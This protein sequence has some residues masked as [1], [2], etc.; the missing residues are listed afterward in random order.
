MSK[1]DIFGR[2]LSKKKRKIDKIGFDVDTSE[3]AIAYRRLMFR[4]AEEA[5]QRG[6]EKAYM[7]YMSKFAGK[8]LD[9][10]DDRQRVADEFEAFDDSIAQIISNRQSNESQR[11]PLFGRRKTTTVV[12]EV[13]HDVDTYYE[14]LSKEQK[15]SGRD[16]SNV[17]MS[18]TRI[19]P[20][21]YKPIP[22]GKL[23]IKDNSSLDY[24]DSLLLKKL[25]VE[26]NELNAEIDISTQT[27]KVNGKKVIPLSQGMC[28]T[29]DSLIKSAILDYVNDKKSSDVSKDDDVKIN[30]V[31]EPK[32]EVK[33]EP[34]HRKPEVVE[35]VNTT[36]YEDD[37]EDDMDSIDIDADGGFVPFRRS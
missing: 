31:P 27:M 34:I 13:S 30:Y 5:H 25:S 32:V 7:Y 19:I 29:I 26:G 1:K 21:D 15:P 28:L 23:T 4:K 2:N 9:E 18:N 3:E 14:R 20:E 17:I 36:S 8:E 11:E 24:K 10:Y 22:E 12:E 6:D 16:Y 35:V 33:E 37:D